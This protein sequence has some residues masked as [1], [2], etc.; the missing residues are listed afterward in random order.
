MYTRLT[1]IDP[2]NLLT[3]SRKVVI[4]GSGIAGLSAA[5]AAA[6]TS[7][8]L[9]ITKSL[10]NDTTT[11]KAQGG[12]AAALQEVSAT[13]HFNDTIQAGVGLCDEEMVRFLVN[14]GINQVNALIRQEVSFDLKNGQLAFTMEG[15]HSHRRILHANG[16][17]T[18]KAIQE[19]LG[20]LVREN[21]NIEVLE[22][23]FGIDL[24]HQNSTCHGLLCKDII[25]NRYLRIDADAVIMATGGLGQIYRETTNPENATGDGYAMC[26]RAGAKLSDMEFV[27]FHPTT[28]YLAGAPRFLISEAVRGEGA[29]LLTTDGRRFMSSFHPSAEL[30]PRDIVSQAILRTLEETGT[31][32]VVLDLSHINSDLVRNRFPSILKL[33]AEYGLDITRDPIPVRPAAHYMMGGVVTKQSGETTVNRLYACGEVACTGVHGANRLASNSLLEGLVFGNQAGIHAAERTPLERKGQ[34]SSDG[35]S[36]LEKTTEVDLYDMQRSLKALTWRC[37][38]VYRDE[39]T[40]REAERTIQFWE[41]YILREE[42]SSVKGYETQNML[43][44]AKLMIRAALIRTESRGAH[45]RRDYSQRNDDMWKKHTTLHIQDLL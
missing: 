24:I 36:F 32:H 7:K 35:G 40:L 22:N 29:Y 37:L 18:G 16:D 44:L 33:C 3:L 5:L 13:S 34:V 19:R 42:F 21:K 20:L 30:A 10:L 23:H 15:G 1:S 28:L 2:T 31:N 39:E 41:Q 43:I 12:I 26:L 38:G 27:Q 25:L 17:A 45:Q 4:L 6:K 8:V 14:E 11:S 9:L